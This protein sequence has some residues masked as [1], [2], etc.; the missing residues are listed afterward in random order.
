[1]SNVTYRGTVQDGVVVLRGDQ[2][3]PANGTE[4]LVTLLPAA[5]GSGAALVAALDRLPKLPPEWVD[6]LEQLIAQGQRP[7]AGP[8]LFTD[9]PDAGGPR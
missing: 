2:Q 4:V 6:E 9:D 8:E 3:A 1:M 5:R 7:P